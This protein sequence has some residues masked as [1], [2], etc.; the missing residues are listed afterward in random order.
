MSTSSATKTPTW[1]PDSASSMCMK[2]GAE[3]GRLLGASRHHCRTCGELICQTCKVDASRHSHVVEPHK[4]ELLYLA[5]GSQ[6]KLLDRPASSTLAAAYSAISGTSPTVKLC[7]ACNQT[8]VQEHQAF[9]QATYLLHT[10]RLFDRER[11]IRIFTIAIRAHLAQVSRPTGLSVLGAN[12][13]RVLTQGFYRNKIRSTTHTFD[14]H[15]N[16]AVTDFFQQFFARHLDARSGSPNQLN[17]ILIAQPDHNFAHHVFIAAML[18]AARVPDIRTDTLRHLFDDP[19]RCL[20]IL[21]SRHV[22]PYTAHIYPIFQSKAWKSILVDHVDL[23]FD[24]PLLLPDLVRHTKATQ[25]HFLKFLTMFKVHHSHKLLARLLGTATGEL[26]TATCKFLQLDVD[27]AQHLSHLLHSK[28]FSLVSDSERLEDTVH[29]P[30]TTDAPP[31]FANLEPLHPLFA[32]LHKIY[33]R[34]PRDLLVQHV[35]SNRESHIARLFQSWY[36]FAEPN[37]ARH[38]A[39]RHVLDLVRRRAFDQTTLVHTNH[40]HYLRHGVQPLVVIPGHTDTRLVHISETTFVEPVEV[41]LEVLVTMVLLFHLETF[42]DVPPCQPSLNVA[43]IGSSSNNNAQSIVT[44][45]TYTGLHGVRKY[46]LKKTLH[47]HVVMG[48]GSLLTQIVHHHLPELYFGLL[49]LHQSFDNVLV[50]I[51]RFLDSLRVIVAGNQSRD[52]VLKYLV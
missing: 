33:S 12:L 31:T 36:V 11:R 15:I 19:F 40:L 25:D 10:L 9:R 46:V 44:I 16:K 26:F 51:H 1:L 23:L 49:C 21:L 42:L 7:Q 5:P 50:D 38:L 6:L 41:P 29:V 17:S 39:M 48:I 34:E 47:A 35:C 20:H 24:Y 13:V 3:F 4:A 37:F 8:V 30:W 22:L 43:E 28:L 45:L 18:N 2:C 52:L 32:I 27:N 14:L